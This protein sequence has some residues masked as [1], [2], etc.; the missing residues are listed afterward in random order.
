MINDVQ[1]LLDQYWDWLRN[2]TELNFVVDR[3]EITTPFLDRH[4]D[5]LQIYVKPLEKGMFLLTDDGYTVEDL[6]MSGFNID[7][8]LVPN[9]SSILNGFGV[10]RSEKALEITA[11]QKI[12]H[13]VHTI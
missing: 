9:V 12:S 13:C 11:S 10:G 7:S 5:S 6:E 8:E 1:A 3:V 2:N 4:N